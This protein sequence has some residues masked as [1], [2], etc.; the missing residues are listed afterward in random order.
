MRTILVNGDGLALDDV[1]DVA[2]PRARAELAPD[3]PTRR[4]AAR[5]VVTDAVERGAVVYGVSPG[6]G[7][8]ADVSVARA[9]LEAMQLALVR[10]H[11]AGI[12]EP[13]PADAVRA[14]L[15]LRARTIAAGASGCRPDL[16]ERLLELLDRDLL[17]T[18]PAMGSGASRAWGRRGFGTAPEGTKWRRES[19]AGA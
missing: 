11:A 18:V 17:P 9:D 19:E 7:A 1:V 3:V 14:L 6:F 16:P 10:S 5:R 8:L 12:G 4:A 2:R 15:L 13:L